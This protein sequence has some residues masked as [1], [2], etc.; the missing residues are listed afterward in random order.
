MELLRITYQRTKNL[1]HAYLIEG[2]GEV[3]LS[4]LIEF[5]EQSLGVAVKGNPD[6]LHLTFNSFGIDEGRRL[7]EMQTGKAFTGDRRFFV[8]STSSFT[9]EAQNS[10]L[11]V[12]EDPSPN[13]HFFVIM[14]SADG[15]LPTLR[16]RFFIIEHESKYKTKRTHD[17]KTISAKEFLENNKASRLAMIKGIIEEKDKDKALALLGAL[18]IELHAKLLEGV[19]TSSKG[20]SKQIVEFLEE[21]SRGKQYLHDRS[22]SVK[23]IL[24]HVALMW[25][26]T[27]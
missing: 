1:H 24:E 19:E 27:H 12:F 16:S 5:F 7:K 9:H 13:V 21:I 4:E 6:F 18:E 14:P 26:E 15:I 10:L 23:L 2:E 3:I 11:K 17:E 22:S 20:N 25:S 8:V